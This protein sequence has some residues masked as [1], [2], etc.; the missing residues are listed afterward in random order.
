[1]LQLLNPRSAAVLYAKQS[2]RAMR[3]GSCVTG[4]IVD[5]VR[6]YVRRCVYTKIPGTVFATRFVL[7][8]KHGKTS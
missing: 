5:D 6:V 2:T 1:M 7:R 3:G 8:R 4:L